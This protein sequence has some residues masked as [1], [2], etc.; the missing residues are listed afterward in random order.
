MRVLHVAA[1][2]HPLVKTGG[3]ADVVGA[4]PPAL[5]DLGLDVRLLLPG[6]PAIVSALQQR[7]EICNFGAMFGASQVRL[8]I[9]RIT[10][11]P[12]PVYV[13]D[14]PDLYN[15]V[16]SPYQAADGSDWPDN[17]QRFALLGWVAAQ[18]AAG[19]GDPSWKPT[20]VHAHDWHAAMACAYVRADRRC[21]GTR[22]VF[23]IHNL[24]FQGLFP[25]TDF[26]RLGL[27]QDFMQ[28]EGL[29]FY[30]RLSFMKAGLVWADRITTVSP[31]YAREI[32]TPDYGCGMD[33][34]IRHR[35]ADVSGILNGV[36]PQVW[37]PLTDADL[38]AHFSVQQLA[39]KGSCKQALQQELGLKPVADAL[40]FTLV[41]RLSHQKGIDLLLDALPAM[42]A[43]GAQ[44]ALLGSGDA[45]LQADLQDLSRRWPGQMGL[46]IGY[47]EALAHRM[48]AGADALLV[49]SRFEP[50]GL[51]QLY[52]LRYGTL[53]LVRRTG[54]LADTVLDGD[55]AGSTGFIF[56]AATAP[57]LQGA[58]QRALQA[59]ARPA[60]WQAM[61]QRAM[62]M[63]F[64]WQASARQLALHYQSLS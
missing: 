14:A 25:A 34:M 39:G 9:G 50:C 41:S 40:L 47:D 52:A 23:T 1:E 26:G 21:L 63:D 49:P 43:S 29:E 42:F 58:M 38:P 11:Q 16:G 48:I 18:L 8:C 37:N 59:Y 2:V 3:L 7:Q 13:I 54:G 60:H 6:L 4:L 17:L 28:T 57:A 33:G 55:E 36:D 53:P 45:Q 30:G 15:R 24:A 5:A 64:S 56:D 27:P 32:A 62:A 61:Q 51:T 46:R 20:I 35:A 12:A 22:T 19:A 44:L 10:S 31:T